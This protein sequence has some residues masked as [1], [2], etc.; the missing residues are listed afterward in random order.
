MVLVSYLRTF[1]VV[2]FRLAS[3]Y[4]KVWTIIPYGSISGT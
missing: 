4:H 3:S 1:C 2:I